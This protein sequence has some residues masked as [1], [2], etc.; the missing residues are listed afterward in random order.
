MLHV[1][2][3]HVKPKYL[4]KI[5]WGRDSSR[6]D[7]FMHQK[8]GAMNLAPTECVIF[9]IEFEKQRVEKGDGSA[10]LN[11]AI[12]LELNHAILNSDRKCRGRLIGRCA[13][14]FPG[15]DRKAGTGARAD[16]LVTFD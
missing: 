7:L 14:G 16:D 6:P 13:Q 2:I 15:P 8:K 3:R 5:S 9:E 10:K 4:C 12:V 1:H 11:P